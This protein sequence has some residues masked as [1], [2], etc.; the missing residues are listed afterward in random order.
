MLGLLLIISPGRGENRK[1][2][3]TTNQFPLSMPFLPSLLA[4]F[5]TVVALSIGS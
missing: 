1:Y 3:E 4:S 5:S 2:L